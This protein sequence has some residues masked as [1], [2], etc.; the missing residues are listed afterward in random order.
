MTFLHRTVFDFLVHNG[1]SDLLKSK[2]GDK[3]DVHAAM[4]VGIACTCRHHFD[5]HEHYAGLRRS[6]GP[7]FDLEAYIHSFFVFNALGDKSMP[8]GTR[9]SLSS[10]MIAPSSA[11]TFIASC[12]STEILQNDATGQISSCTTI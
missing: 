7:A 10:L 6:N 11:I 9:L 5:Y 12:G 4:M 8:Q 3:F 1:V 2:I